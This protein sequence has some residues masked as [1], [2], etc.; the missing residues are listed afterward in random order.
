M[1]SLGF[2]NPADSNARGHG[3]RYAL[4]WAQV[5]LSKS[6]LVGSLPN[7]WHLLRRRSSAQAFFSSGVTC[8][9]PFQWRGHH[10]KQKSATHL[11]ASTD[12]LGCTL[13]S[14]R[15][16]PDRHGRLSDLWQGP[17][18]AMDGCSGF[19]PD[20]QTASISNIQLACGLHRRGYPCRRI[21][22]WPAVQQKLRHS[23]RNAAAVFPQQKITG[24]V[25]ADP[26]AFLHS[27]SS[28]DL[29]IVSSHIAFSGFPND[30]LSSNVGASTH[31]VAVPSGILTRLSILLRGCYRIRRHLNGIF[32]CVYDTR[33]LSNCQS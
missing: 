1:F 8:I 16:K 29:R 27:S 20:H 28:P 22:A 23:L 9:P 2:F 30:R 5:A 13:L 4:I 26:C 32:T 18:T 12:K 3:P 14:K 15:G 24:S 17:N 7:S 11:S 19:S 10:E 33:L 31:T 25:L 21:N 6:F